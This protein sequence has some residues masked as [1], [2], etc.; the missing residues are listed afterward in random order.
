MKK[1]TYIFSLSLLFAM[2]L[3]LT[4]IDDAY[5]RG[6]RRANRAYVAGAVAGNRRANRRHV[7]GNHNERKERYERRENRK[8]FA[9]A[10]VG[11][12]IVRNAR[13]RRERY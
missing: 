5:A 10:A 2:G 1:F 3:Y 4:P 8:D 7:R 12:G 13:E 11:V 6:N 9:R